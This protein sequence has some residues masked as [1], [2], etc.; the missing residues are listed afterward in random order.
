MEITVP[1]GAPFVGSLS[2]LGHA[3]C[4]GRRVAP[5]TEDA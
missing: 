5:V 4:P 3:L 1:A 2:E